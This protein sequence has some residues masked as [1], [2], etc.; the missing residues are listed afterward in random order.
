MH[1]R[2]PQITVIGGGTGSFALLSELKNYTNDINALVNMADDGGSTGDLR[3]ELGVLPPGD[4]R[5]CLSALCESDELRDQFNYRFERGKLKGHSW[6]N[7][8]LA[9]IE[10]RSGSFSQAV[11]VASEI[12][13]IKGAVI[14]STLDDVHLAM[15]LNGQKIVGESK[16]GDT[17]I[18]K[19]SQPELSLEPIASLNPEAEQAIESADL[20]VLAPGDLYRSIVPTLLVDGMGK[21]LR[22]ASA[23][24]AY[25]SNLVNKPNHT[26]EFTVGDYADEIERFTGRAVLDYVLYNTD[27]PS[28]ELLDK[29]ALDGEYPVIVDR[30]QLENASYE[31]VGGDFL[32][33]S[34][35][36]QNPH[37]KLKR[38]FIRHDGV[39]VTASLVQLAES[40]CDWPTEAGIKK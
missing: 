1:E 3:D 36:Q 21:A 13:N 26:A 22:R 38:S 39:S 20:I 6:G 11:S 4:V 7:L 35:G 19:G 29:Y 31:A 32:S 25:V 10:E 17:Y 27:E 12:L 16:I 9:G 30:E 14:P 15:E 18:K 33:Y 37:D 34:H 23:P 5:Q 24:V 28:A 8:F 2:D 40:H